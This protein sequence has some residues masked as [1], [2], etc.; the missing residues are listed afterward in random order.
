MSKQEDIETAL[1]HILRE[2]PYLKAAFAVLSVGHGFEWGWI[3]D[4][5]DRDDPEA[6]VEIWRC[7]PTGGRNASCQGCLMWE[8]LRTQSG[9]PLPTKP[10]DAL[11]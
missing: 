5:G 10:P 3:D 1:E 2:D 7:T 4:M 6:Y 9:S 8:M 11:R